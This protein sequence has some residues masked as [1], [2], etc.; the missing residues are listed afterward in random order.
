MD[1]RGGVGSLL[2]VLFIVGWLALAGVVSLIV[3]SAVPRLIPTSVSGLAGAG[4]VVLFTGVALAIIVAT[5]IPFLVAS[6][7]LGDRL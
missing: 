6:T 4:S 7:W 3:F 2:A 5:S 1:I